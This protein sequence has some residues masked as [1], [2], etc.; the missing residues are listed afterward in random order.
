MRMLPA[1]EP[2]VLRGPHRV[3]PTAALRH[4]MDDRGRAPDPTARPRDPREQPHLVSRPAR[5]RVPRRPAPPAGALPR[6]G[7]AVRQEAARASLLRASA[8]DPGRAEPPTAAGSLDAGGRARSRAASASRCSP[9]GRSRSTSSRW[10]GS[11]A[12]RGSRRRPACRSRR[13]GCGA[14][15]AS[16]SRGGSRTGAGAS[17][18]PWSS[19]T[20]GA[21]R[22][23]RGRP[24]RHRPDHGRDLRQCVARAREIYPQRPGP[25][26]DG[27]WVRRPETAR[28]RPARRPPKSRGAA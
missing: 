20:A 6:Q 3:A 23:R 21:G 19:A 5:A 1:V 4:Q 2:V 27:W 16:C 17:P 22:A 10:R 24:R 9:R 25:G 7:R 8:P 14:R 12:R 11:P 18:R 26:D 15:T 13:S 28:V